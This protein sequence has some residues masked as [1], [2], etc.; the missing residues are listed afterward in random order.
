M[1]SMAVRPSPRPHGLPDRVADV[2]QLE[3]LLSE[4]TPAVLEALSKMDGDLLVLGASGK[5]GPGLARMARRAFEEL[6]AKHKVIAVS[7]FSMPAVEADLRAGGVETI[8]CDLLDP[9]LLLRLPSAPNIA[10]LAGMK[11]GSSGRE[12]MTWAINSWLPGQVAH[13]FRGARVV[14]FSTGNVYPLT[15]VVLGGSLETDPA[16]PVGEYA[17]SCLGR[18]RVFEYASHA[19]GTLVAVLRLNYAVEL[20]Y[21]V[22]VDLAQK[23]L[24]GE[25]I[26]LGMGA[27]NVI[28]QGDVNAMA[29]QSFARA[30]SPPF[31]VNIAGPEQLSVRRV[32]EQLGLLLDRPP[33]FTG[34]EGDTALLSNGQLGHQ[35]FGYPRVSVSQLLAWVA[36][37]VGSGRELLRRPTHFQTRDGRF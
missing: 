11:F 32:A 9:E 37:W 7:R 34:A 8:S 22:L 5:I 14:V 21:G 24:S 12:P 16:G 18:E 30:S 33:M 17:M 10:F 1:S 13:R 20:R 28:W 15:P 25:E 36:D 6:G 3:D 26:A 31:V 2:G 19:H 4:P 27:V 23:I 35:L 29:L